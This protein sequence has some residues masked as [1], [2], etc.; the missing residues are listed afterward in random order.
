MTLFEGVGRN[1]SSTKNRAP[2][3]VYH[4]VHVL[5]SAAHLLLV[6]A[7][8]ARVAGSGQGTRRIQSICSCVREACLPPAYLRDNLIITTYSTS[9]AL[10]R[11]HAW[12]RR[13]EQLTGNRF[14]APMNGI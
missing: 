8:V 13:Q 10:S 5:A 2:A 12:L 1:T 7:D 3:Q 4:D 6:V 14:L 11:V 9:Y